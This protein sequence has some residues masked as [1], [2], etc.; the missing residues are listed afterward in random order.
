M[1]VI[2]EGANGPTT[3]AADEILMERKIL[4]IPVS[5][6]TCMSECHCQSLSHL[7]YEACQSLSLPLDVS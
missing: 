4:V 7:V 5:V 1:Q 2:A 6:H 3:I